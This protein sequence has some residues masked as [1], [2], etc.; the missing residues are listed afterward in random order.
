MWENILG[1]AVIS[2]WLGL[3][4]FFASGGFYSDSCW[5]TEKEKDRD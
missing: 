5:G 3:L 4:F 2:L 1:G